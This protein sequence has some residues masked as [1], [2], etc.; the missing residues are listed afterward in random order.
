MV[1]VMPIYRRIVSMMSSGKA[2]QDSAGPQTL[3]TVHKFMWRLRAAQL[4]KAELKSMR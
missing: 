4:K 3:I 1:K 2:A